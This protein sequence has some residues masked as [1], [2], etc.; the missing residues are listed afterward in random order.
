MEEKEQTDK[1][2]HDPSRRRFLQSGA[3]LSALA[4]AALT[5]HAALGAQAPGASGTKA[6]EAAGAQEETLYNGIVLP[7]QWPP[8]Y[9]QPDSY[10]PMPLPYLANGPAVISI[11]VGRQLFV[12]DFLVEYTNLQRKFHQ[13]VKHLGNPLL[14][15]ETKT[16][17][18]AGFCPMAAP[19]SDGCFYDPHDKLFK[20]WYMAGWFDGTALAT[21]KDGLVWERPQLDVVPGTNLVLAPKD[22][23]RRDGASVWLDHDAAPQERFKMYLYARRGK[24]GGPLEHVGAFLFTSADG[25]HWQQKKEK[26]EHTSDNNTF[27][28]NP[29]R[30]KWVFT[31]RRQPRPIQPWSDPVK[32]T[33]GRARSYWEHSDFHAAS[34]EWKEAVFWFGADRYDALHPGYD[35]GEEPQI[36]KVDAVG[37]ESLMLGLIQPHY[38]PANELC[39]KGGFPK[40]TE[41]QLAFSRDGFH[42][43][44]SCRETFIGGH[45]H[46]KESWERAYIHSIGGVCNIVGDRLHFYYTAFQGNEANKNPIA[47]FNGMYANASMGLA[48]LR[49]DGFA[50]METEAEGILLTR[51]VK[52][53]GKYLFLNLDAALG[54]VYAEVCGKDGKPLP[55]YSRQDCIPVSADNTRQAVSWKAGNSLDKFAG[56]P[57]RFKFYLTH[58]RLYAFWVS[59]SLEGKSNGATAAGGPGLNGYWDV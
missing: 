48:V 26:I 54:R 31:I 59:K 19:F 15:P 23:L 37:Y 1:P 20:L 51:P 47:H 27:F 38:G 12:D 3:M 45:P 57:V 10:A 42:W 8:G 46:N 39:A 22:D 6:A 32:I 28:Y 44:R 7:A 29:F 34:N 11:D 2:G 25:I 5:G 43:D 52:F 30:K 40:L 35:I 50:S 17:L 13:P 18:N 14:K 16:E 55:G 53:T 49:R 33:G 56:T 4:G 9:M 58:A 41:L 24:I 36:Y 21:S